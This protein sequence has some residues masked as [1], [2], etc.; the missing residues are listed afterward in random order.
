VAQHRRNK[1]IPFLLHVFKRLMRHKQIDSAMRLIIV[2]IPGPE[3]RHIR[4]LITRYGL[5]QKVLLLK[6]LAEAEL[7]WC[8]RN[9]EAT[10]APSKIEGF[11][12][13]VVEALLAG[14][15]VICSDIPAFRELGS[16][17][18]RFVRLDGRA[19]DKFAE[20][21]VAALQEP[22][23]EPISMPLLSASVIAEQYV[24]LYRELLAS[25]EEVRNRR[26]SA[27]A[28]TAVLE[29]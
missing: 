20:A 28:K 10:L 4:R 22:R 16:D 24:H 19:E 12:L 18:C 26:F 1:N 21:I 27:S 2:G 15:R 23:S 8:Y 29:R 25:A 14:C 9:C 13:P 5:R 7:Q 17:H 3:T 6:G 11:G